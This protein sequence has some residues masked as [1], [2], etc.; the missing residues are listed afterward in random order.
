MKFKGF[1]IFSLIFFA[2]IALLDCFAF[3]YFLYWHF[4]WFDKPMHFLGGFL[5]A[6]VAL[7]LYFALSTRPLTGWRLVAL[8]VFPALLVGCLWELFEFTAERF[9]FSAITLK[10]FGMLYGGW[11]DALRDLFFDLLGSLSA[12]SL[13]ITNLIWIK[14]KPV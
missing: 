12:A 2:T 8:S 13:F 6:L 3:K 5:V 7:Q 11:R 10:T 9:Y 1:F 4:R 14:R